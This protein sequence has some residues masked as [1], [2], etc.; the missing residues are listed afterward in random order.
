MGVVSVGSSAAEE[1]EEG[2]WSSCC[3]SSRHAAER[4]PVVPGRPSLRRSHDSRLSSRMGAL[5]PH[6]K[7]R[8]VR[9]QHRPLQLNALQYV[10][11]GTFMSRLK[12]V[13]KVSCMPLL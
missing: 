1:E 4:R 7:V 10:Y 6:N 9:F 11:T 12:E 13:D 3:S 5:W 2:D 8:S